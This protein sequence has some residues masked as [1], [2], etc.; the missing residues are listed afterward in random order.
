M[1][2]KN[3]I[4]T[5]ADLTAY[6]DDQSKEYP[7]VS[8]IIATD[9]V[10]WVESDLLTSTVISTNSNV[11]T[12]LMYPN[13]GVPNNFSEI[14]ID[15]VKESSVITQ[16]KLSVGNH[17]IKYKLLDNTTIPN[18]SFTYCDKITNFI[19]SET[20]TSIGDGV[21]NGCN[22]LTSI[23]IPNSVTSIGN[24]AFQSCTGLTSINIPN[25]V[26]SIGNSAFY[27]C[28]SLTSVTI[29]DSVTS[30]GD[31]AFSGC[32]SLTSVTVETTTPP[33]LGINAFNNT[34]DCPI[35]VPA[36]SVT[37]YQTAN[38]WSTYASRIQAIPTT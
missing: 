35:Y 7:N 12:I 22:G 25:T 5:Y 3:Q 13:L 26:T 2:L 15:G 8:Y 30:I 33:T 6:N 21:F 4:N 31:S 1:A 38:R 11:N 20:I 36:A 14:W 32:T 16:K 29:P 18:N 10:K 27:Y 37:A 28:R 17:T 9:E 34:N 19:I 24:S 23:T